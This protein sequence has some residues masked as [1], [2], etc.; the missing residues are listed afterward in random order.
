MIESTH[1]A[2]QEP[3][4]GEVTEDAGEVTAVVSA[5]WI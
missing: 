2:G 5:N 3:E 4:A 1:W